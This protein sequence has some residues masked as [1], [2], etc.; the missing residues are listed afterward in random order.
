MC[1]ALVAF[2]LNPAIATESTLTCIDLSINAFGRLSLIDE[3]EITIGVAVF[4]AI[5]LLSG[6]AVSD[7]ATCIGR[8]S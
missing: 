2:F 7:S 1:G 6:Y 8:W 3:A 4:R 5:S